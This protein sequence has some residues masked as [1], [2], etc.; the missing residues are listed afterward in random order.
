MK[1]MFFGKFKDGFNRFKK[2]RVLYTIITTVLAFNLLIVASF[3]W[4]TLNRKTAVD[5]M[6]MALA[7]DDTTAVYEAYMY[8]LEKGTGTDL[9]AEGERLNITN[10]DLNQYDTIFKGQNKYTPVFAKIVLTRIK[11]MPKS[12]KVY[13]TVDRQEDASSADEGALTDFTSSIVRFTG[14]IISDKADLEVGK[15]LPA[16]QYPA[17]LYDFISTKER[18]D[19]IEALTGHHSHSKTFVTTVPGATEDEHTHTKSTSLTIEVEYSEADWYTNAD[20]NDS[21]HVYLYISYDPTLVDCYMDE[22]GGN[23]ISLESDLIFF[24]NDMKEIRVGYYK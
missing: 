22:H 4:L 18:F 11:D 9:N 7:V 16:E 24:N 5:E 17:L 10:I 3:A 13:I 2:N 1:R 23:D 21:M 19:S 15:N 8:D 14:F 6:G 12:G 20:G